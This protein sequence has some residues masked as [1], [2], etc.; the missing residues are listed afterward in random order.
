MEHYLKSTI[1]GGSFFPQS[2]ID[3]WTRALT[4]GR[5]N[6]SNYVSGIWS[7]GLILSQTTNKFMTLIIRTEDIE[8][9]EDFKTSDLNNT[10]P[11]I[12][13]HAIELETNTALTLTHTQVTPT[14]GKYV[15]VTG[16]KGYVLK[17]AYCI[18]TITP[19][20][21]TNEDG[22]PIG[23]RI[24]LN[25]TQSSSDKDHIQIESG[26]MFMKIIEIGP[27]YIGQQILRKTEVCP[28]DL[29]TSFYNIISGAMDGFSEALL[30][31][32]VK[33]Y[34]VPAYS[35]TVFN[36][37]DDRLL[38]KRILRMSWGKAK[39]STVPSYS[40]ASIVADDH[41]NWYLRT[42]VK[43]DYDPVEWI[44]PAGRPASYCSRKIYYP[45]S[46]YGENDLLFQPALLG[47]YAIKDTILISPGTTIFL[48][49]QLPGATESETDSVYEFYRFLNSGNSTHRQQ[50]DNI[51]LSMIYNTFTLPFYYHCEDV[52]DAG[53][54][55]GYGEDERLVGDDIKIAPFSLQYGYETSDAI[56]EDYDIYDATHNVYIK[57][58]A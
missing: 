56:V 47:F 37:L 22:V 57:I 26:R 4:S 7:G 16:T 21:N 36:K 50:L 54:L 32:R 34:I 55:S 39:T 31:P 41:G 58:N 48:K 25:V 17:W 12:Y 44:C 52:L 30:I 15:Q 13:N 45:A 5:Y 53:Y 14:L 35:Q 38:L 1:K 49:N 6:D 46:S 40:V 51:K 18:S 2:L 28:S 29:S 43:P 33:N 9:Y 11:D 3:A 23:Q 19:G 20:T 27:G 24:L 10:L 42:S 8:N